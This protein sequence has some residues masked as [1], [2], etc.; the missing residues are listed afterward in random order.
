MG[1]WWRISVTALVAA[2]VA[3]GFWQGMESAGVGQVAAIAVAS[4]AAGG[5]FALGAVWAARAPGDASAV[6]GEDGP[7]ALTM[8]SAVETSGPPDSLGGVHVHA[9]ALRGL[10]ASS[11]AFAGRDADIGRLMATLDPDCADPAPVLIWSVAGLAGVGKTELVLHVAHR[12]LNREGWFPGG[13]L[14]VNMFGYD[15]SLR[16]SPE[17]ALDG[18]LRALGTPVDDIPSGLQDR[19]RLYASVLAQKAAAGERVLVVVDNVAAADQARP[20]LPSDGLNR[21]LVTSRHSLAG[22][23]ARFPLDV[24]DADGAVELLRR[25]LLQEVGDADTR[26]A[27]DVGQ[28]RVIASLTGYLPLAL[29]I[30]AALLADQPQRPLVSLAADLADERTRLDLLQREDRAVR[31]AFELSCRRLPAAQV[32]TF[33]LMPLAPGTDASTETVAALLGEPEHTARRLLGD[34][35]RAHLVEPRPGERWGMHDLIRLYAD[36]Q[37]HSCAADDRR[38]DAL[39]RV[40]DHYVTTAAM[41]CAHLEPPVDADSQNRFAGRAEALA[42]LDAEQQNLLAAVEAAYR[43][44]RYLVSWRLPGVVSRY[45]YWRQHLQSWRAMARTSVS[46]ARQLSDVG[47]LAQAMSNLG[48]ALQACS[49]AS[50]VPAELDEAIHASQEAVDR[51][52]PDHP[53]VARY[54]SNLGAALLARFGRAGVLSDLDQAIQADREATART[55]FGHVAAGEYLSNLSAALR[56]RY[57]VSGALAELNE[58]IQAGR[59]AIV[60]TFPEDPGWARYMSQL[61]TA[62][63]ARFERTGEL[64]DLHEAVA[65]T[66]QAVSAAPVDHPDRVMMLTNFGTAMRTRSERTGELSD[67]DAAVTAARE[68]VAAIPA[69]HPDRARLLSNLGVALRV[70]FERTG[71]LA[72]LDAAVAAARQAVSATPAAHPGRAVML[73]DLGVA[74][75]VRSEWTGR[76]ADLDEAVAV[77]R[78]AV[79]ATPGDHSGRAV[80]LSDLGVALRI[81]YERTGVLADLDEAEAVA[82]EAASYSPPNRL[83]RARLLANLGAVRRARFE[84]TSALADL[85]EALAAA[86]E[87]VNETPADHADRAVMLSDLGV[88]LRAR[89]ERT[90]MPAD[91]DEAIAVARGAVSHSPPDRPD[92]AR[93]LANLGAVLRARFERTGVLAD[94]D[95]A[96]AAAREAVSAVPADHADRAVMLSDLSA[97]LRARFERTGV[98]ADLGEALA[99]AREAAAMETALPRV[100][101][102]AAGLWGRAAGVAGR[103]HDAMAAFEAAI[104]LLALVAP[105]SL[106][107]GDQE[108]LLAGL[109]SLAS[110]AAACCIR[111]GRADRAIELLEQG[112]GIL[113]GQ[114]LD[115]RTDL[116]DLAER[117]PSM[118]QRFAVLRDALD[119]AS[120]Q[121]ITRSGRADL[122]EDLIAT[123]RLEADRRRAT[124]EAFEQVITEIRDLPGFEAFL[125]PPLARD[126]LAAAVDGPVVIVNVSEFGSHALILTPG[127]MLEPVSLDEVTPGRLADQVTEL[128]T[129]LDN[130]QSPASV[131]EALVGTLG[132]LWDA[133]AS[134]VLDRLGFTGPP[135]TGQPWPRLWWCLPGLLSF[136]PLHAAG[137]YQSETEPQTVIDRAIS[138]YTPTLRALLHARA[139][140]PGRV[141]P[142]TGDGQVL[143][144]ANPQIRGAPGL[145]GAQRE[146]DMLRDLFGARV[147]AL[148][149]PQATRDAVLDALPAARWAHFACN[150][151]EDPAS[152]SASCLLL[153][154][155]QRLTVTEVARLRLHDADLAFL[156]S[157]STSRTGRRLADEAIH[158][159][160]AF[161]L[162]G[163]RHVIGTLWGVADRPAAQ[164][165]ANVYSALASTGTADAATALHAATRALRDRMPQRPFYW[166]SHIHSGP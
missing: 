162:A 161:Q 157:N 139:A 163:Y 137:R 72:D 90:G 131:H 80:M 107:R 13:A 20:L 11:D 74:L 159:A 31:A 156:S 88:A 126:L 54:M 154:D 9:V 100:R 6:T 52:P 141:G 86:R 55:L 151:D 144:V 58:A 124:A 158:L 149:G 116:T 133:I 147:L 30:V 95:E 36:E 15:D 143:V 83:D 93:L 114:A 152:P 50:G 26:V 53:H 61:G 29:Q 94:L 82:L 108:H 1:F 77:A 106:A 27:D 3:A 84:R 91:L 120:G 2:A 134:P 70:R 92:R 146:A 76:P 49:A 34:L 99:A 17:T 21:A 89:F 79:S 73:S 23:G 115:T 123:A 10:P 69:G 25:V 140:R 122:A 121:I 57:T 71:T 96:V 24:L 117:H 59:D 105:R 138:S 47:Q 98:L 18:F 63:L 164:I 85:D 43:E 64:A 65:F 14:F 78:Q 45:M 132:W 22:L 87:A 35:A 68:A 46:A 42:W 136:M 153:A 127:G 7:S 39:D 135:L 130:L 12:A 41:A 19:A 66:R 67:L 129:T 119:Q 145:P 16:L 150:A 166:A 32:R 165:A 113:L 111:A 128:L 104:G 38:E 155:G 110:D 51:T 28:A 81:R 8:P 118:A 5:V 103:W 56:A 109:G 60:G 148:T 112:R 125:R 75:R 160:S 48:V 142:P 4:V 40:L 102:T 101:V 97:V 44:Q 37:G 62:L 33:R